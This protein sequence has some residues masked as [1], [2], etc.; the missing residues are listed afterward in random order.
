MKS[1][2]NCWAAK[3]FRKMPLNWMWQ[4]GRPWEFWQEWCGWRTYWNG[5]MW[6]GGESG[7]GQVC[8]QRDSPCS[9][10]RGAQLRCR[11]CPHPAPYTAECKAIL[12][13]D[14]TC[15]QVLLFLAV[16]V[17]SVHFHQ[18]CFS[19]ATTA[20]PHGW[21]N[22]SSTVQ[23]PVPIY[24]TSALSDSFSAFLVYQFPVASSYF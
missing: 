15:W 2:D 20:E 9:C 21:S 22:P 17:P 1:E 4:Y 11:P 7:S 3:R 23:L 8:W 12:I 10:P 5:P 16:R 19:T 14:L 6:R 18:R 24:F 13:F